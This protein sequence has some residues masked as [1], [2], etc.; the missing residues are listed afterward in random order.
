[1]CAVCVCV[2]CVYVCSA[3]VCIPAEA[4]G[5]VVSY[6]S[7]YVRSVCMCA[8]RVYVYLLRRRARS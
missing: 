4:A 6:G 8:V 1:M 2:Q 7:W 5:T 3:C